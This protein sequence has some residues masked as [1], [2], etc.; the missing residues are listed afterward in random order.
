MV[1]RGE[2]VGIAELDVVRSTQFVDDLTHGVCISST[3][4]LMHDLCGHLY[5]SGRHVK[6]HFGA[7]GSIINP[8]FVS[9]ITA[10]NSPLYVQVC[11]AGQTQQI[12]FDQTQ[13]HHIPEQFS[14]NTSVFVL[15][16]ICLVHIMYV[17]VEWFT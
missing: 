8:S 13:V 1:D 2:H 10:A 7:F 15:Q 11:R 9:Q 17:E 6:V 4:N 14:Q 3:L 12:R 5:G 16:D